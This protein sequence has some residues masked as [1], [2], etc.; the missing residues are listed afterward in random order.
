MKR[1]N[2]AVFLSLVIIF[3]TFLIRLVIA[4]NTGLG[5]G[6]AYYFRGAKDLQLSYYDQPPLF[7]WLSGISIRIFGLTNLALRIPAILFFTGT[8]CLLFLITKR[9]FNDRAGFFT[10]VILNISFVFTIPVATWFQPDAPLMFFW[11]LCTWFL[12]QILFPGNSSAGKKSY[13]LWI[14]VGISFGLTTLSKYHAIFLLAGAFLFVLFNKEYHHW[15]KHPGPYI[16]L[17]INLI[18]ALPILIWNYENNWVSFTFQGSRAGSAEFKLHFDWFFRSIVGQAL[19]LAPWIWIPLILELIRSYKYGKANPVYSF[20]FWVSVLPVV[21]FTIVTLWSDTGFHFHWQAPGYLML[22]I[23]LGAFVSKVWNKKTG[24]KLWLYIST[25]LTF[26]IAFVLLVQMNTG[27]VNKYGFNWMVENSNQ[28]YDP[29]IEGIDYDQIRERFEKEGWLEQ[30]SLFVGTRMWWQVGKI[31]WALKG[32]K[33][34]IV[35]H[36]DPRNHAFFTDPKKLIGFDAVIVTQSSES[37]ISKNIVPFFKNS[38]QLDDIEI[39]RNNKK[40]ISLNVFYCRSFR[41]PETPR[42]DLPVY[43]ML[44]NKN[45]F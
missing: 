26:F 36:A 23:P 32:E 41:I 21:F 43:R 20:I 28:D 22:F 2:S 44:L 27:I 3:I 1:L 4:N 35:F 25:G 10:V 11:L 7:L 34:V 18:I 45:P 19:W 16:A 33:D 29:T 8:S 9:L 39:I 40:E 37:C 13:L 42:E 38:M 31:D 15:I 17:L 14:L 6:E 12:I 5:I 30:D 24:V